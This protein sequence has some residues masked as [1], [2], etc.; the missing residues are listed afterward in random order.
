MADPLKTKKWRKKWQEHPRW[1]RHRK[2][3]GGSLPALVPYFN[4]P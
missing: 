4:P 2:K 1:G 3:G